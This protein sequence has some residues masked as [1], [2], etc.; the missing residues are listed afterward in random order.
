ML[1]KIKSIYQRETSK[2]K[3]GEL[4]ACEW[5]RTDLHQVSATQVVD[6]NVIL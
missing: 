4:G 1:P 2:S 3:V 5:K 6:T